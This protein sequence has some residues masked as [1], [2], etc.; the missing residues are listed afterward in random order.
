MN[1]DNFKI[2]EAMEMALTFQFIKADQ[3]QLIYKNVL[4]EFVQSL[5]SGK[6]A[7]Q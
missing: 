6:F 2:N 1:Q 5:K 7:T 3:V 4:N